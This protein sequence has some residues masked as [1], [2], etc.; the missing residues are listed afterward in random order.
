MNLFEKQLKKEAEKI[1][2]KARERLELRDRVLSFMQYHP[3]ATAA[4][5]TPLARPR[6]RAVE[7]FSYLYVRPWK[8]GAAASAMAVVMIVGVSAAA[9]RTAPGDVLYP[10]KVQVNEEILSQL[11]FSP[12]G[13]VE[14]ETRR[15]ERRIAEARLLAKEGKL[16]SEVEA[17]ITGAVK[18]HTDSARRGLAEMRQDNADDAAVAQVVFESA[19]DVQTAVLATDEANRADDDDA[20]TQLA[21]LVQDTKDTLR[22]ERGTTTMTSYERFLGSVEESTT[23][24]H[25]L[26]LSISSSIN[27]EEHADIQRRLEDIGRQI[28]SAKEQYDAS[29]PEEATDTLKDALSNTQKLIA[30]MTDI[31]VRRSVELESL[32]PKKLTREERMERAQASRAAIAETLAEVRPII[33]SS[34]KDAL[35]EKLE[36]E[37]HELD[38]DLEAIDAALSS[39]ELEGAEKLLGEA[40]ELAK[41]LRA[42][43]ETLGVPEK[44]SEVPLEEPIASSTVA[45][46]TTQEVV[47][48]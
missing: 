34:S 42:L 33:A 16:T 19:L 21:T 6:R 39:E 4:K 2:L 32:V 24:A 7:A 47:A 1:K 45:G 9:E 30:Y 36:F 28:E 35:I 46:T 37:I 13:R 11:S 26:F 20:I 43:F 17:Q 15:V 48:E 23:R 40:E 31:D 22:A 3:V 44:G 18:E 29:A 10:V 25:E 5:L 12:Y 38:E 41:D 8:F 14:W 27:D